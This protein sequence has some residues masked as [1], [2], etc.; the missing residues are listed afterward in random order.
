[1]S[2]FHPARIGPCGTGNDADERGLVIV[3]LAVTL[4]VLLGVSAFGVDVA[5]WQTTKN[6]EQRAADAAA[7]AGAVTFPGN[8]TQSNASAGDIA[9]NNGYGSGSSATPVA[10]GGTCS[11][12]TGSD[13]AVCGGTGDQA[14][15][16]K[17]TVLKRVHNFFGG[18]FGI[19]NTTV[20]ATAQAEYLKPLTMG[21]PSN[22]FGNDPDGIT[23]WPPSGASTTY[24]NLWANIAG[25]SS[26]KGKGD[27]YAAGYCDGATDGCSGSGQNKNLD[28]KPGGY[29]YAVDFTSTSTVKLQAFDP[30][31]VDVGDTCTTGGTNLVGAAALTTMPPGYPEGNN[32]A[33]WAKRYA[34][35]GDA[36]KQTDPGFQYCTGDNLFADNGT[37]GPAPVTTF[38]VLKATVPGNPD[39]ALP[40]SGC[41]PIT[42]PGFT[43]DVTVPLKTGATPAGAPAP[44]V[45]YFRQWYDLCQVSGQAGD[46]YFIEV[47]TDAGSQGHNRYSVRGVTGSGSAAPVTVAGN[48][49]M[50]I[51]ANVGQQLTQFYLA[52]VPTAAAH[53]TLVLNFFDIG[54]ASKPGTLTIVPPTDSNVGTSFSNCTW[55]G[56]IG[57][58]ATGYASNTAV[59]PWGPNNPISGCQITGVNAPGTSWNGQWSTV[60]VPIPANYSCRDDD[61]NGCWVRINYQFQGA[62]SDTTSWN[63]YLLGDPVRLTK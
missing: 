11:I 54:D 35:V 46:E 20:R 57:G 6:R 10:A 23:S 12:T 39:G 41:P 33:D 22:Q 37:T 62:I 42:F 58:S 59:S 49:Y 2:G 26:V 43:G 19:N 61:T 53:H 38:T 1:M 32:R 63:A 56:D 60:T 45:K 3:W 8:G 24:P 9:A 7:L 29:Y 47:T 5:Y 30:A 25:G 28:K 40:V 44:F 13:T 17:V 4:T 27:A 31:F 15:Q 51:Y 14:Y 34:P 18:I 48:T 16:Y 52:R 50:G 21:S 55:T 36:S